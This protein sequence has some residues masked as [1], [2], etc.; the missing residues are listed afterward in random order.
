MILVHKDDKFFLYLFTRSKKLQLKKYCFTE[1][2]RRKYAAPQVE[3]HTLKKR[4]TSAELQ[5]AHPSFSMLR[6]L[7]EGCAS[8]SSASVSL[9]ISV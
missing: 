4:E 2:R 1:K 9:F 3:Q 8:F 6:M 7:Q 5:D